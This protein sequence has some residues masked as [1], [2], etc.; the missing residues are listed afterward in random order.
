MSD[1]KKCEHGKELIP[2]DPV[3][4]GCMACLHREFMKEGLV[5]E[6]P[7]VNVIRSDEIN[8]ST[9]NAHDIW[10]K[11]K[12]D[13]YPKHIQGH[14]SSVIEGALAKNLEDFFLAERAVADALRGK[15]ERA[16]EAL[17]NVASQPTRKECIEDEEIG[18]AGVT[19]YAEA[20][21]MII[22]KAREAL[23]KLGEV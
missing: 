21:D 8:Q 13:I 4:Y 2:G 22:L 12:K 16:V 5:V 1:L 15:L 9:T 20:Y 7:C 6:P 23:Q 17:K 3:A 10:V 19:S 14:L 11:I 18:D